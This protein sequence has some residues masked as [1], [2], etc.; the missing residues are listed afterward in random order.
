ML[1]WTA[2]EGRFGDLIWTNTLQQFFSCACRRHNP[3]RGV[4]GNAAAIKKRKTS[5][6]EVQAQTVGEQ[7]LAS[8]M[9][10]GFVLPVEI[11]T[12]HQDSDN[13]VRSERWTHST[14]AATSTRIR[15]Y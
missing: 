1:D 11:L 3:I 4:R 13:P 15:E 14:A 5:H 10:D 7:S 12:Q 6:R 2:Q 9:V 8:Q